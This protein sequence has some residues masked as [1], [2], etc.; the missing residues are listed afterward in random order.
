[1]HANLVRTMMRPFDPAARSAMA[2]AALEAGLAFTNAIL[3]ATHAM[4]HQAAG[5]S[6]CPTASSTACCC[7][8]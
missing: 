6:T 8:T 5:C 2:Q 1:M 4:S 3:G 7:R